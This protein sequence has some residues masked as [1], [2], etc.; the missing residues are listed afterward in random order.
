MTRVKKVPHTTCDMDL[1]VTK[2]HVSA[3]VGVV[4]L[5]RR[6]EP[7]P[8]LWAPRSVPPPEP[9]RNRSAGTKRHHR[10]TFNQRIHTV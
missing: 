4:L 5:G 6:Q 9:S 2:Q 10:K 1:D 3:C 7:W 8:V